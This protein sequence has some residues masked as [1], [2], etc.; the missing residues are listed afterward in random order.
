MART[1]TTALG[2]TF[3][4]VA[5]LVAV[6]YALPL[7]GRSWVFGLLL[8]TGTLIGVVLLTVRWA[9]RIFEA[10]RP[11]IV[12]IE[13]LAII[14]TVLVL[15]FAATYYALEQSIPDELSGLD[16]KTDALYF[17]VTTLTTVGFGDIVP[18][19]QTA[20]AV[21]TVQMVF[22]L[23]FLGA[24]IR[25]LGWAVGRRHDTISASRPQ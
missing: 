7:G 23:A 21:A 6:Y 20:R 5:G 10:Q 3:G 2:T 24:L 11:L 15:S 1:D 16:T 22:D 4:V 9:R 25:L 8:G 12:A 14:L 19:G 17:T 13:A 18:T